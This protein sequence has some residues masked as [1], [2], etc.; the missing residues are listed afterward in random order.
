MNDIPSLHPK[1]VDFLKQISR[2]LS[3]MLVLCLLLTV[4]PLQALAAQQTYIDQYGTWEYNI[5]P[6]DTVTI[7]KYSGDAK[8][9]VIPIIIDGRRVSALGNN[10]FHGNTTMATVVIPYGIQTIGNSV[11]SQCTILETVQIPGT[12][13]SIGNNAFKDCPKLGDIYIPSSVQTIGNNA[14]KDCP[15]VHLFCESG[16]AAED[17]LMENAQEIHA[18]T[19]ISRQPVM[20][21]AA[22]VASVPAAVDKKENQLTFQFGS[23]TNGKYDYTLVVEDNN[24]GMDLMAYLLQNPDSTEVMTLMDSRFKLVSLTLA[25]GTVCTPSTPIEMSAFSIGIQ[26]FED[27]TQ[28]C[29]FQLVTNLPDGYPEQLTFVSRGDH[30]ELVQYTVAET[31]HQETDST[32]RFASDTTTRQVYAADGTVLQG[33]IVDSRTGEKDYTGAAIEHAYISTSQTAYTTS[34]DGESQREVH[35]GIDGSHKADAWTIRHFNDQGEQNGFGSQKHMWEDG[36]ITQLDTSGIWYSYSGDI[37]SSQ[38]TS[39]EKLADGQYSYTVTNHHPEHD[40]SEYSYITNMN[41]VDYRVEGSQVRSD[42]FTYRDVTLAAD[43][44]ETANARVEQQLQSEVDRENLRDVASEHTD[45]RS[46]VY[47]TGNSL[48]DHYTRTDLSSGNQEDDHTVNTQWRDL[49]DH[50][51]LGQTGIYVGWDWGQRTFLQASSPV[52]YDY[53]VTEYRSDGNKWIKTVVTLSNQSSDLLENALTAS[54][55]QAKLSS[56]QVNVSVYEYDPSHSSPAND[57]MP[58]SSNDGTSFVDSTGTQVTPNVAGI[59]EGTTSVTA[60]GTTYT[61]KDEKTN[62]VGIMNEV[63][64]A[65][66]LLDTDFTEELIDDY[67]SG[68]ESQDLLDAMNAPAGQSAAAVMALAEEDAP[69]EDPAQPT[70]DADTEEAPTQ[71]AP[72]ADSSA[73]DAP[74]QDTPVEDIPVAEAP[75]AEAAVEGAPAAE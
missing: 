37:C 18:F 58:L 36:T 44:I 54:D 56:G 63:S 19:V 51:Y 15:E 71:T 6:D 31:A 38:I 26:H 45:L 53:T 41:G 67:L 34:P 8:H 70:P 9:V 73:A 47:V 42:F 68:P 13:T 29:V 22:P 30:D 74:V 55:V 64:D 46:D 39:T 60:N 61:Q 59:L 27:G 4:A 25:D 23:K 33:M 20:E 28:E 2:I 12:V 3:L 49:R 40:L 32:I 65:D 21:E 66:E 48:Q 43:R 69:A 10:L 16:S 14:F 11:F 7:I 5:N 50:Q 62:L 35:I 1:E 57:W 52:S 72:A 75:S 24:L 17:Y